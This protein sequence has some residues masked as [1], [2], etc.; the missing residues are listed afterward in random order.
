MRINDHVRRIGTDQP[1]GVIEA[2]FGPNFVTVRW[3]VENNRI[4][5]EDMDPEELE[6]VHDVRSDLE[7]GPEIRLEHRNIFND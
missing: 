7:K 3:G 1:I 4:Y 6:V 5:K 2:T